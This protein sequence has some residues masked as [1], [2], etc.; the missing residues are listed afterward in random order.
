MPDL[1]DLGPHGVEDRDVRRALGFEHAKRRRRPAIQPGD[2][3][4]FTDAVTNDRDV[5]QAR[6]PSPGKHD[7]RVA[8]RLWRVRAAQNADRLLA[9]SHLRT[10]AGRVDVEL[11]KLLIDLNGSDPERLHTSRVQLDANLTVDATAA[12]NLGHACDRQEALRHGVIDEPGKSFLGH[13]WRADGVIDDGAAVDIDPVNLRFL[14]SIRQIRS[15]FR[16][17]VAHIRDRTVDRCADLELNE[18]AGHAFDGQ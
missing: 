12:R 3:T 17:C 16:H 2:G 13:F 14:D 10:S 11:A 6:E 5:A 9:A 8:E 1:F 18:Y 15:H 7:A 4:D